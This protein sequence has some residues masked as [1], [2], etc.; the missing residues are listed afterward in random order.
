MAL[1]SSPSPASAAALV[2]PAASD[3]NLQMRQDYAFAERVGTKTAWTYFLQHYP[4]GFYANLAKAQLDKLTAAPSTAATATP[5]PQAQQPQPKVQ[6]AGL[7][8]DASRTTANP[9]DLARS[10]QNELKRV[11]CY[12]GAI[13]GDWNAASRRSLDQFNRYAPAK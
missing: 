5:A 6:V 9:V 7:P 8:T 11:G 12:S 3:P 10:V 1:V 4:D 13:D 2:A